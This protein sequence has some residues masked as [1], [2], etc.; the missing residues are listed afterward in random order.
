MYYILHSVCSLCWPSA[1]HAP[2]TF[3][4][5]C[6]SCTALTN[7]TPTL[8]CSGGLMWLQ[9]GMRDSWEVSVATV[10]TVA[11]ETMAMAMVMVIGITSHPQP[12]I[13]PQPQ[14]RHT[15]P[16]RLPNQLT[17]LNPP[18]NPTDLLPPIN[19]PHTPPTPPNMLM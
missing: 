14:P 8:S 16:P 11:T 19:P 7:P 1:F 15:R 5:I 6:P 17:S 13:D 3:H 9:P 12:P 4:P 10:D 18:I 2:T